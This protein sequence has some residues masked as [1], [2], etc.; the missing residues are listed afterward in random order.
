LIGHI[1]GG[2]LDGKRTFQPMNINFGLLPTPEVGAVPTKG[3]DGKRLRGKD[4][5]RAKKR[6]QAVRALED[7]D[8]WLSG[9]EALVPAE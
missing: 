6:V 8:V 2:H 7:F 9:A 5:G 1:T 4:K 3:E